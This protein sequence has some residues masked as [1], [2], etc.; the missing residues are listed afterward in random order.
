MGEVEIMEHCTERYISYSGIDGVGVFRWY[1][2]SWIKGILSR[3]EAEIWQKIQYQRWPIS[4]HEQLDCGVLSAHTFV[5]TE[6][7]FT[8]D[9]SDLT[10]FL[11]CFCVWGFQEWDI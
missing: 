10:A 9:D 4:T 2:Y 3:L 1:S 6:R 7:F 11:A 5:C 8:V